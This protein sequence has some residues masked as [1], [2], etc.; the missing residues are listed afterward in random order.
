MPRGSVRPSI[1]DLFADVAPVRGAEDLSRE[2]LF[3]EG[4]VEEF[5]AD[6]HATRGSDVA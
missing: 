2:G 5:L 4:E 3:E 1:D 6:L